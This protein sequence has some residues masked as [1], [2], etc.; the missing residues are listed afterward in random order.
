MCKIED[1]II[2]VFLVLCSISDLR[3]KKISTVLLQVMSFVVV[4]FALKCGKQTVLDVAGGILIGILFFLV[5]KYTKE[6]IGYGDSWL[7]SLLGIYLGGIHLLEVVVAA[8]FLACMVSL[9]GIVWKHWKKT[10]TLPFVPFL[11]IAYLVV[12]AV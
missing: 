9:V 2:L 3:S 4:V 12:I 5:S 6:A 8:F 7:M 1:F 10:V 11:T